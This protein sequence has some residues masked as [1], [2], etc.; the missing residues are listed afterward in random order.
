L[1]RFAQLQRIAA[2]DGLFHRFVEPFGMAD[3]RHVELKVINP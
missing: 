1:Q 2:L 3:D